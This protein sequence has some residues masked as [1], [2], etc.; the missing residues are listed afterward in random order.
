MNTA[1]ITKL[2][3]TTQAKP[4]AKTATKTA[5]ATRTQRNTA[6]AMISVA[7]V[8]LAISL[9]DISSGVMIITNT[10]VP[11]W[12]AWALAIVFELGYV[13]LDLG[14]LACGDDKTR[15]TVSKIA[16]PMSYGLMLGSAAINALVFAHGATSY[17]SM[18]A[19][20]LLGFTI[21]AMVFTLTKVGAEML[22]RCRA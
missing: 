5:R 4:R 8:A 3:V 11:T 16:R 18:G 7:M 6:Y 13:F 22:I 15:K 1:T 12:Q 21:T 17:T 20:V 14:T 10:G 2:N 9:T 19:S